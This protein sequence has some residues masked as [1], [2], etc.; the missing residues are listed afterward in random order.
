MIVARL[1]ACVAPRIELPFEREHR[2]SLRVREP[3]NRQSFILLP[4][5]D[6]GHST[7][8][9]G[10]DLLPGVE[11]ITWRVGVA[12]AWRWI[13]RGLVHGG[14]TDLPKPTEKI[15]GSRSIA[16]YTPFAIWGLLGLV[17]ALT[18]Q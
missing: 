9:I 15:K 7:S 11:S 2:T 4:P 1:R 6:G 10:G 13:G 12:N 14:P 8:E 18:A 17:I 16:H 5:L 3:T